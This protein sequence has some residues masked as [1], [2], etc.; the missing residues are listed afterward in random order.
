MLN[1]RII[2]FLTSQ[3]IVIDN[4]LDT[5]VI[6]IFKS[7][8][9]HLKK[10]QVKLERNKT[11]NKIKIKILILNLIFFWLSLQIINKMLWIKKENWQ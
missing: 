9:R 10:K 5:L 6:L 7:V 4:I 2:W 8:S 3:Y 1:V 11:A